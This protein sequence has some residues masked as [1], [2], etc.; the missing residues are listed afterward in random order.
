MNNANRNKISRY[1]N[2]KAKAVVPETEMGVVDHA[3]PIGTAGEIGTPGLPL[4]PG[5]ENQDGVETTTVPNAHLLRG[6]GDGEGRL[7]TMMADAEAGLDRHSIATAAN[8]TLAV[9]TM[10]ICPCRGELRE[11]FQMFRS[12]SW[13]ILIGRRRCILGDLPL[14]AL[15]TSSPISRPP[16]RTEVCGA[17]FF[18]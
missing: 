12:S 3:L 10:T 1:P 11:M 8:A 14:H 13:T 18:S 6:V 2:R 17:T 4:L 7:I 9:M 5:I 16:S 15:E